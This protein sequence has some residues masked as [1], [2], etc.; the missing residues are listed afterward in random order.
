M[1][2]RMQSPRTICKVPNARSWLKIIWNYKLY[3]GSD[4]V[5]LFASAKPHHRHKC[6]EWRQGVQSITHK[7]HHLWNQLK[8]NMFE[9]IEWIH[10]TSFVYVFWKV[11][12][13]YGRGGQST[14]FRIN[15]PHHHI[16]KISRPTFIL[17]FKNCL[18]FIN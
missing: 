7:C 5:K 11:W 15:T 17:I 18:Y 9:K 6:R 4:Y 1:F 3:F 13:I 10:C 14:Y 12:D 8:H 2:Q 16:S